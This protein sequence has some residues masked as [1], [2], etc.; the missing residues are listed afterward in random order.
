MKRALGVNAMKE[1]TEVTSKKCPNCLGEMRAWKHGRGGHVCIHEESE[2]GKMV[3]KGCGYT[4]LAKREARLNQYKYNKAIESNA[5]RYL[6]S[7]SVV[8]NVNVL[9]RKLSTFKTYDT[10]SDNVL[11][12]MY[13]L[14]DEIL[15]GKPAHCMLIGQTGTGKTHLAVGIC[16]ELIEKSEFNKK[17][18]FISYSELYSQMQTMFEIKEAMREIEQSILKEVKQAD[19]VVIDDLGAELGDIRSAKQPTDSNVKMI[20]RILDMR[21]DKALVLTSNLTG[22]D[23]KEKYGERVTSRI[24]S[25]M[26]RDDGTF[27]MIEMRDMKD[28]RAV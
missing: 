5:Y 13:S 20:T 16:N 25:N 28:Y 27:R 10:A 2:N 15:D 17:V 1:L 4:D 23:I 24:M 11:R 6:K 9:E 14:V 18:M 19:L 7:N 3:W 26:R 8:G 22:K 21:E 12:D